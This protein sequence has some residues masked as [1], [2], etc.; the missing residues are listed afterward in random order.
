MQ[1]QRAGNPFDSQQKRYVRLLLLG[2][3]A[4]LLLCL[5]I[6]V[7]LL[8]F[9][10]LLYFLPPHSPLALPITVA[11]IFLPLLIGAAL[12]LLI[13]WLLL[14]R[15]QA[16]WRVFKD[17]KTPPQELA[18]CYLWGGILLVPLYLL[19]PLDAFFIFSPFALFPLLLGILLC[20]FIG[21][22]LTVKYM[23][24]MRHL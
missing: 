8:E 22:A 11:L 23:R 1:S 5:I 13:G 9:N 3:L 16:V 6:A 21:P 14:V 19:F 20:S 18:V 17:E 24:H 7:P 10:P 4:V 12:M 15:P 2:I